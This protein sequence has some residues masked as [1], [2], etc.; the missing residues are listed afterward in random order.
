MIPNPCPQLTTGPP[1]IWN[2]AARA[3]GWWPLY[4]WQA[5]MRAHVHAAQP[6]RVAQFHSQMAGR[7]A[8]KFADRCFRL[9]AHNYELRCASLRQSSPAFI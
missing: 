9:S 6:T 7:Q 8:T 4:K 2:W 1:P 3:M 5:G